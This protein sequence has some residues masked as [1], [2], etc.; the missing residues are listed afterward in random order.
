MAKLLAGSPHHQK[1]KVSLC[2]VTSLN[3]MD[4]TGHI[5]PDYEKIFVHFSS[6]CR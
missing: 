4:A 6:V 5:E 1:V 2:F 3:A